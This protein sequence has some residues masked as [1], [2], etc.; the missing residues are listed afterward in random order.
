MRK[1]LL[2]AVALLLAVTAS[3]E[4]FGVVG[5][6]TSSTMKPQDF[7]FKSSAGV[8]AGIAYNIP[9]IAGFALQPE[10]IYNVKGYDW[11]GAIPGGDA[12]RQQAKFGYVEVPV[13]LQWGPDL[14]LLRPY[15]YAEPF[16]GFAVNGMQ[17]YNEK[18]VKVDWDDVKSRLEYGMGV[19]A[20]IE[21]MSRFQ[22][23]FKYF[24]NVEDANQW[25]NLDAVSESV[26][27][28]SFNG[29]LFSVGLFF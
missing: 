18:K 19:G 6:F 24:W 27:S 15:V 10:L 2:A 20:G 12:F 21:I 3:A 25:K 4:G 28:R 16:I 22:L 9:L 11:N 23:S 13:Q 5:G 14:L 26:K 17:T 1:L 7:T 29:L 8:H